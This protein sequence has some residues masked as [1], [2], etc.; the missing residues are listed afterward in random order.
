MRTI[1]QPGLR[2]LEIRRSRFVCALGRV[3]TEQEAQEFIAG[4]RREHRTATHN[5][6]AYILGQHA[7]ITRNSDDGEPA[8]TAGLPMLEVLARRDLTGTVAVVSRYFGG[9]KLGAGGLIRAYGQVVAATVDAVGVVE[10]RPVVTVTV[11]TGH[12]RAGRLQRDLHSSPYSPGESRYGHQAEFD[13][14]VPEAELDAF[15]AWVA[16]TSGGQA[17]TRHG[18]RGHIDVAV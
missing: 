9:I 5:C 6:T 8:G 14:V 16:A 4:R 18:A 7:D 17:S 15:D 11:T 12:A 13:V 1:R 2:E 10:R 3:A